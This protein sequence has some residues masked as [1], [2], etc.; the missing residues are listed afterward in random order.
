MPSYID[1]SEKTSVDSQEIAADGLVVDFDADGNV[2]GLDIDHAS[3]KLDLRT[4]EAIA[5]PLT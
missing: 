2:V 4:L 1:L 5:L 3:T